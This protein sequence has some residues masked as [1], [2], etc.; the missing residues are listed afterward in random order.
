MTPMSY[1][2]NDLPFESVPF[3]GERAPWLSGDLQTMRNTLLGLIPPLDDE[4]EEMVF[5]M[6]DGDRLIGAYH[7]T[8]SLVKKG[9]IIIAHGLAG[10]YDSSYVRY[11]T[12][13]AMAQGYDALRLN[14]RGAGKGHDVARSSYHAGR[15]DDLHAVLEQ[16]AQAHPGVPLFLCAYSLGGTMAVNM[17]SRFAMPNNL[18]AVASF[19]APLDMVASAKQFHTPRNLLYN[20]HFT[21]NLIK[22]TMARFARDKSIMPEGLTPSRLQKIKSVREFDDLFTSQIAGYRDADDYYRGTSAHDRLSA[23]TTPTLL[24]HSD[25]DPLIPDEAYRQIKP[26]N[27]VFCVITRGG[28]HVGFHGRKQA[29]DCWQTKLALQFFD[30]YA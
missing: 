10:D 3:K 13:G 27:S 2:R 6:P 4:G 30:A 1:I 23:I 22:L 17:V 19:C 16:M 20:R 28:G 26:R 18:K 7:K 11:L 25:N 21:S 9:L 12:K 24:C 29:F 14:L 15:A 8:T 5:A